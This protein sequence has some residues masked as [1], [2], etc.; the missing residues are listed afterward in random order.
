MLQSIF[1]EEEVAYVGENAKQETAVREDMLMEELHQAVTLT[2]PL[3]Y[4]MD[5]PLT[6]QCVGDISFI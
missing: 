2:L 4:I 5:F 6:V 1:K 3:V